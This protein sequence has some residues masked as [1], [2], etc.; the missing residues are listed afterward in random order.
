M[1]N[2]EKEEMIRK[3]DEEISEL[4]KRIDEMSSDFAEML[5]DTLTKMQERI[6]F[7]NKQW[8]DDND[9]NMMKRLDDL[10]AGKTS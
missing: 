2:A 8:E 1:L 5:K 10:A 3:K 4:K 6:E 7:A 9:T